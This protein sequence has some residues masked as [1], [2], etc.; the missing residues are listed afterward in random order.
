MLRDRRRA[1]WAAATRKAGNGRRHLIAA[2]LIRRR[3]L[4]LSKPSGVRGRYISVRLLQGATLTAA[5]LLAWQYIGP[6]IGSSVGAVPPPTRILR[7]Y[8]RDGLP[9]YAHLAWGTMKEAAI[10]WLAGNALAIC[11]AAACIQ[12]PPIRKVLYRL[13]VVSYSLPIVAIAPILIILVHGE[14]PMVLLSALA[15]FF[16]TLIGTLVGLTSSVEERLEIIRGCGGNRWQE[17]WKVRSW[18]ALP[19]IFAAIKIAAPAAITAAIVAEFMAGRGWLGVAILNSQQQL[20]ITRT[21]CLT[22]VGTVISAAAY[23]V[24]AGIERRLTSWARDN[25]SGYGIGTNS[26][27]VVSEGSAPRWRSSRLLRSTMPT[28]ACVVVLLLVWQ[29]VVDLDKSAS[30]V[31]R[32]PIEVLRYVAT[33]RG[34]GAHRAAILEPLLT[35]LRDSAVGYG[36]GAGAGCILA[37]AFLL[38]PAVGD[39]LLPYTI[40]VRTVPLVALTPVLVLIFGHGLLLVGAIGAVVTFFPTLVNVGVGLRSAPKELMDVVKASGGGALAGTVKVRLHTA[41]PMFFASARLAAPAAIVAALLAEWF[42]TG[43]GLGA[44]FAGAI[45]Q[46]QYS[47][48]WAAVATITL[49]GILLYAIVEQAEG[50]SRQRDGLGMT[51]D[52]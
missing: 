48:I 32:G 23:A 45:S 51:G 41:L 8:A 5:L 12:L 22:I 14:M 31:T 9:F 36:I 50:L 29:A 30:A 13:S 6:H 20:E 1:T 3:D 43:Q 25:S 21:W 40:A 11:V 44:I 24:L 7:Q 34:A 49:L 15:V 28:V 37:L 38:L 42:G 27:V 26:G 46:F 18:S 4:S 19:S 17:M 47:E 16:V 2:L 33:G 52:Q 10:G 39:A 35:T